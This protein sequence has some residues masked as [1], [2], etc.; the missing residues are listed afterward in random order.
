MSKISR[1]LVVAIFVAL[2]L[3]LGI[4]DISYMNKPNVQ[5]SS[6]SNWVKLGYVALVIVLVS[7]YTYVREKLSRLKLQKSVSILYRYIY[8]TLIMLA[9]TFFKIH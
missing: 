7:M 1:S 3:F 4:S 9:T 2:I 6:I 8:I 5:A